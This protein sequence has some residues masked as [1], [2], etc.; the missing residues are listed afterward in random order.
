[1]CVRVD[2]ML[3]DLP[4]KLEQV[5][6]SLPA[7]VSRLELL[8]DLHGQSLQFRSGT[9]ITVLPPPTLLPLVVHGRCLGD[10]CGVLLP[11]NVDVLYIC[12]QRLQ[13]LEAGH[14]MLRGLLTS[15]THSLGEVSERLSPR[16]HGHVPQ[17]VVVR[18]FAASLS[19]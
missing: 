4:Q 9:L 10:V 8:Q 6:D 11:M 7:I 13:Q 14:D 19:M 15:T 12:S 2:V 5:G 18:S 1:M 3:V 16:V 17:S